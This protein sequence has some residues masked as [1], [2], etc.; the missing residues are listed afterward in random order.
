[1]GIW[2][3]SGGGCYALACAA[4]LPELVTGAAVFTSFAPGFRHYG[5]VSNSCFRD[6]WSE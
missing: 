1:M 2:G 4:M 3:S 6:P 5:P